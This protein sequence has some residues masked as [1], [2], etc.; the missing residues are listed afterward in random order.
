[1]IEWII[2]HIDAAIVICRVLMVLVI[3]YMVYEIRREK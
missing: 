1:M 3:A 2:G